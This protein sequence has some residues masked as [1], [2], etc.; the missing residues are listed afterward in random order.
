MPAAAKPPLPEVPVMTPPCGPQTPLHWVLLFQDHLG[1]PQGHQPTETATP[2]PS[3]QQYDHL[4]EHAISCNMLVKPE[5]EAHEPCVVCS[6]TTWAVSR[7]LGLFFAIW[8]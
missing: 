8:T 3:A 5:F 1:H 7:H 2:L 4:H 6:G